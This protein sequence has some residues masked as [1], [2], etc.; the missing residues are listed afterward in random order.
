MKILW[1]CTVWPEPTSSAAGFRTLGLMRAVHERGHSLLVASPACDTVFR[2]EL[3]KIGIGTCQVVP[4]D[5]AFDEVLSVRRP[6]LVIFDRFMV[7]EQ[8]SWRVKLHAPQAT[9]VLDTVDLH[10]L[11]RKREKM[12]KECGNGTATCD[13][14]DSSDDTLREMA[15]IW[16]SDLTLITSTTEMNLL[17]ST[18]GVSAELLSLCSFG[19]SAPLS[20]PLFAERGNV[21]F[22]GNFNHKPNADAVQ[23]LQTSLW[24]EIRSAC[25]RA[26]APECQLHIYGAYMPQHLCGS[27]RVVNGIHFKGWAADAHEALSHYR[28]NLAPLRF[29]AGIKGKVSDGWYAGTPCVGTSLAAEGMHEELEFGGIIAND[30]DDFSEAVASLYTDEV[31][32]T[33]A[34]SRGKAIINRHFPAEAHYRRFIETLEQAHS[35]RESRRSKNFIGTLLWYESNRSTEYFS[36][37]IECKNSKQASPVT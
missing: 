4:N 31:L 9:R 33:E 26:G 2:S 24:S 27:N 23:Y 14:I 25:R 3:E 6:D 15:A 28:V 34:S 36:R 19:Y 35:H 13:C 21:V 32:W 30:P 18:Y 16:R 7:E 11:R 22:I 8:F 1:I 20:A 17:V 29:G 12:A 37:W 10:S 5:S